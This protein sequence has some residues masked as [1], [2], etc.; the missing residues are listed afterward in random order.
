[1]RMLGALARSNFYSEVYQMDVDWCGFGTGSML[2]LEMPLDE[3]M[4]RG[5]QGGLMFE[6]DKIG[7]YVIAEAATGQVD[8]HMREFTYSARQAEQRW[9]REALP[10]GVRKALEDN[11]PDRRFTFVHSIY[12]RPTSAGRT[13]SGNKGMPYASCFVEK[14]EQKLVSESGFY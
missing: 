9:G 1:D 6:A 12:P 5:R 2:A 14:S 10:D 11:Q 8:T 7:R 13:Y 3:Q 4:R